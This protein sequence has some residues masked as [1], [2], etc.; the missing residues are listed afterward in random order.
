MRLAVSL[1]ILALAG[2]QT[3]APVTVEVV[4]DTYC[5][6]AKKRSWSVND[7]PQTID[8]ARRENAKFDK[9]CGIKNVS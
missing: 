2:C 3:P 5:Q 7:T 6:I 4:S 8:E 1:L 9:I